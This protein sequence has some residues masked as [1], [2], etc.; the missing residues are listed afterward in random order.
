[1]KTS[2]IGILAH[3]DAG[4][5]SLTERLLFHVGVIRELG[6]V[7]GGS[8]QTDT[9]DLERRRGIT[10][11]AA[12]VSFT[13]GDRKVNLID[14]PGHA[15]FIAEVERSIRVLD[16][17][18]LVISAVE[19]V[20]TQTRVLMRT[21]ARLKIPTL[22]F[23]NKIDRMGA[24][25]D[26]LLASIA[27]KLTPAIVPMA[28]VTGLGTR[29]AKVWPDLGRA[30]EVL[31]GNDDAF[32]ESYLEDRAGEAEV[33]AE[34]A[35]QTGRGL[36]H[37][38][39]FGSAMTG[40]G[41]PELL[42]GVRTLLPSASGSEEDVL[43]ATVFKIERGASGEKVAYARL[44]G[45]SVSARDHVTAYRGGLDLGA[46]KVT[47]IEPGRVVA[48]D[49]AK[50]WGLKDV[51][52][53]DSLGSPEPSDE[54]PLFRPPTLETVV[55]AENPGALYAALTALADQD[56]FIQV[57]RAG[58]RIS[59]RLYGEVQKEV[60]QFQLAEEFGLPVVF[61]RTRTLRVERLVGTGAAVRF[62][63][64][65]DR[66]DPYAT[67]GLRVEPGEP[68][69]GVRYRLEVE[70]G[71]LPRAFHTAI[72]ETVQSSLARG[73]HGWEVLDCVVTLTHTGY[74]SPITTAGDFRALTPIVLG[75]ALVDAGT[76]VYEPVDAFE[77]SVPSDSVS[78]VLVCL[79]DAGGRTRE[80]TVREEYATLEGVI[81]SSGVVSFERR[82][83][84]LT[85]GE[86][87]L[88]PRFAGF[89]PVA[90]EATW[91]VR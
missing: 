25:Y 11:R 28:T 29:A 85:R 84:S 90:G 27:R 58:E 5:T 89:E 23:V 60:L 40:E 10:I 79:S 53:G 19:G 1:M 83:P 36:V 9:L 45:G 69:S 57:R 6:S 30:A 81:P 75:L 34:L 64:L 74:F 8:T 44:Y 50:L 77:L 3:V 38:V 54:R 88:L 86:G 61:E 68:G 16:G 41:V 72:E 67:V 17:V 91:R 65:R 15:D 43:R 12:V 39:Y 70:L 46:A 18:V 37:P 7:D 31:A 32:L 13:V 14:T 87:L 24:A 82:L 4:K 66:D 78:A 51:R 71:S 20:Q 2:N 63:E 62:I 35:T 26:G 55:R 33:R 21:L 52:I 42:E 56:P 73:P 22:L 49:I 76:R 47:A 80:V 48:G 59:V